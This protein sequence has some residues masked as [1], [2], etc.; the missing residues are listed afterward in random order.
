MAIG[1]TPSAM[2]FL[3]KHLPAGSSRTWCALML[4]TVIALSCAAV[5]PAQQGLPA[6]GQEAP[7]FTLPL[8]D[9]DTVTLSERL[10]EGPVVL[11]FFR[12]AW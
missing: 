8:L 6:I 10:A 3:N 12:G 4:G 2:S 5:L 11:V 7:D 1:Y 9:G